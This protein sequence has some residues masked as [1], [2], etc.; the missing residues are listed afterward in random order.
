VDRIRW[1]QSDRADELREQG[2]EIAGYRMT[3]WRESPGVW[4]W[5]A[6]F[7]RACSQIPALVTA[8]T[9]ALARRDAERW[10]RAN[11]PYGRPHSLDYALIPPYVHALHFGDVRRFLA[12]PGDCGFRVAPDPHAVSEAARIIAAR[13]ACIA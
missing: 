3:V 10:A 2:A 1:S 9:A 5:A 8:P 12:D 6:A 7:G 4:R 11:A 13:R